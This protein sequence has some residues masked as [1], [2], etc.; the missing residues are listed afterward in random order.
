MEAGGRAR[1]TNPATTT[2]VTMKGIIPMNCGSS[3]SQPRNWNW[4]WNWNWN[5]H[6]SWN[7]NWNWHWS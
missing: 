3:A 6:W 7:W 4:V 5:W 2:M 1:P